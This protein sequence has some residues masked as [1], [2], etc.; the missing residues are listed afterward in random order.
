MRGRWSHEHGMQDYEYNLLLNSYCVELPH[1]SYSTPWLFYPAGGGRDYNNGWTSGLD[2]TKLD[3]ACWKFGAKHDR[4]TEP[5][6]RLVSLLLN[7]IQSL[8]RP[9]TNVTIDSCS[10]H[11]L[12]TVVHFYLF[13]LTGVPQVSCKFSPPTSGPKTRCDNDIQQVVASNKSSRLWYSLSCI[14]LTAYYNSRTHTK[15]K[16]A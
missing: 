3:I 15:W 9:K 6:P 14:A 13:S 2:Y 4:S 1:L 5:P 8:K 10:R 11:F 16:N 12:L 7:S